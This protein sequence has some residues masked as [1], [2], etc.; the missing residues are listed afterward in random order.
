MKS[1]Y[2]WFTALIAALGGLLFGYDWV[3]IGGAKPFYEAYF[4]LTSPF[5]QAWA[6]SCALVGCLAGA[7]G[8][9]FLSER[10]GRKHSLLS[11]AIIF[12]LSSLGTA[13][14]MTFTVFVAWRT[15]GGVGIGM[16]S[17]LSPIYIAEIAPAESRGK[18]VCLNE[19]TIVVGILLA[20][21]VNWLIA[22]PVAAG[23]TL[24]QIHNSWNGQEG[25]RRMFEAAFVPAILF[26]SG[27]LFLPESPRWLGRQ[28]RWAR[29][30]SVLLRFGNEAYADSVLEDMHDSFASADVAT[31][32]AALHSPRVLR[33]L[34]IGVGLAVLQQWCGI[35]VI[36]NYAQEIFSAAGYGLSSILF[37]IVITGIVMCVFTFIAIGT[38]ERLGRR[39]LMLAGC[40][41]LSGLYVALGSLYYAHQHGPLLLLLVVAAIACYAMT[42]AP[43]T[44]VILSEIFPNEVRGTCMSICTTALWGA[45]FVLT[46]TF[47]MLDA[48]VG[49]AGTFWIYAVVCAAG[50]ALVYF[51][52]PETKQQTL[53][54]IQHFW[55]V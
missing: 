7:V 42:L 6:M 38:V 45:C 21:T 31:P 25:W 43:V 14:A 54:Q 20:Q 28:K 50:F 39:R 30:K 10:I 33:I 1:R 34:A 3:V 8:S 35:N 48:G 40:A 37:D 4:G 47:P 2:L 53:E 16:A 11:S 24:L 18:L 9:G 41:G 13:M 49:T 27:A 29:A 32:H 52:L 36:F 44:W 15:I 26:T 55:G 51:Q 23:A 5:Q 46:Y 19:L 17:G 12:A 22:Q